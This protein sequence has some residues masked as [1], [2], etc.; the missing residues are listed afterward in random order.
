MR[1]REIAR[2]N[3][4]NQRGS[5]RRENREIESQGERDGEKHRETVRRRET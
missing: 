4:E 5:A 2:E 1:K 3:R